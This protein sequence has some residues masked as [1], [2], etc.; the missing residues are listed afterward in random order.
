MGDLRRQFLAGR[1][2]MSSWPIM[3]PDPRGPHC[4]ASSWIPTKCFSNHWAKFIPALLGPSCVDH[5]L[6]RVLD[7]ANH[8]AHHHEHRT[9]SADGDGGAE[10]RYPRGRKKRTFS[11][12]RGPLSLRQVPRRLERMYGPA[13]RRKGFFVDLVG[14]GSC[15]NVSG[16]SLERCSGPSWISARVRSH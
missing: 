2:A 12:R 5:T 3:A 6:G 8:Y 16:L 9:N 14:D 13:V 10:R 11:R 1:W 15:I 7:H 4:R